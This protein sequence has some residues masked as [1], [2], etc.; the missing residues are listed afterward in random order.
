MFLAL[1]L[2]TEYLPLAY[3]PLATMEL[4]TDAIF[5]QSYPQSTSSFCV[6]FQYPFTR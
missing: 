6:L 3:L 1:V 4:E 5:S 2:S